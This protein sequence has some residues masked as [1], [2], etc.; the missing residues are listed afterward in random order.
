MVDVLNPW[1]STNWLHS[2]PEWATLLPLLYADFD[3]SVGQTASSQEL[4]VSTKSFRASLQL[5]NSW[6]LCHQIMED[7]KLGV[8]SYY[9]PTIF[10]EAGQ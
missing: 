4:L 6:P 8:S 3:H 7:G 1:L 5:L 9:G 2:K 10:V